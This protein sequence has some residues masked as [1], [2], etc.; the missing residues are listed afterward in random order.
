M[1]IDWQIKCINKKEMIE[2]DNG[3]PNT[4]IPKNALDYNL[5]CEI[6]NNGLNVCEGHG[7]K[8]KIKIPEK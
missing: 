6:E 8:V 4:V 2:K 3:F 1:E 7:G 5:S